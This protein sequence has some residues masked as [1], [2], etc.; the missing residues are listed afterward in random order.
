MRRHGVAVDEGERTG[1]LVFGD[2]QAMAL[3]EAGEF[4]VHVLLHNLEQLARSLDDRNVRHLRSMGTTSW[5]TGIADGNEGI[6][7]CARVNE[8]YKNTPISGL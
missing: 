8:L 1:Q 2:P 4:D 5:L 6:Y 3:N 7:L